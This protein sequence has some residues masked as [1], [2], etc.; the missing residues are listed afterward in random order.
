MHKTATALQ[1][2]HLANHE[3]ERIVIVFTA[4]VIVVSIRN[5]V[6]VSCGTLRGMLDSLMGLVAIQT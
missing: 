4:I 3:L 5:V 1:S 2:M 6:I